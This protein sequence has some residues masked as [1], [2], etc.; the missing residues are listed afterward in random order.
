MKIKN[1]KR[2]EGQVQIMYV[3]ENVKLREDLPEALIEKFRELR[4]Y[5]DAGD[6][7]QF[8]LLF[9]VVEA[10]VKSYYLNG[11]ISRGDLDQIFKKYGIA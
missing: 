11:K 1:R 7:L 9:E 8:D 4:E 10:H 6:W 5:Y 2:K 3:D